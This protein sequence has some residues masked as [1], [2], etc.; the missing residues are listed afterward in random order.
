MLHSLLQNATL[1]VAKCYTLIDAKPHKQTSLCGFLY[2][3]TYRPSSSAQLIGPAHRPSSSAQL[4]GP[5]AYSEPVPS[6][7]R[8]RN[9]INY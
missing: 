9:A 4:I 2:A 1:T 8:A 5:S 6:P 7:S 3:P